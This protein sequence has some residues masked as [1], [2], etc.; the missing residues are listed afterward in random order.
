MKKI[1]LIFAVFLIA[2]F[3]TSPACADENTSA[4]QITDTGYIDQYN[5]AVDLANSGDYEAALEAIN[6][7][8]AEEAN[9][10]LGYATKSGILYVMGDF[11]GA[12]EAA[13]TATEIQ[14]EQAWGWISKSNALLALERY[15]EALEAADTAIEI[16]PNNADYVNAYINKGTALILL[17]RYEESIEASD[18]AIEL[19][20]TVI[21]G[22]INKG[23]A[24]EYLG[25]Y[26]EELEVCNKALEI[27]PYNSMVWANKRYAEKM[28]ENEQNPQE[29][30]FAPALAVLAVAAAIIIAKRD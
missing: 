11:T 4:F 15:D 28:I 13:D 26:A 20:P 3:F 16:D 29:S 7:S 2:A 24:L 9:F 17:G 5:N 12:L 14:P 19:S 25:R 18:K 6:K 27:D 1:L 10:A 30:P 21:E 22:Y 23:N 8:L